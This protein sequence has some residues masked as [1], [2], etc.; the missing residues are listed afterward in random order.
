MGYDRNFIPPK[1]VGDGPFVTFC[2]WVWSRLTVP[3]IDTDTIKWSVTTRGV[4][5]RAITRKTAGGVATSGMVFRG[6][7]NPAESYNSQE[8]VFYTPSG[9]SAGAY[10]G[11]LDDIP[12]GTIP[13]TGEP[14]W[15][16]WPYPPPGVWG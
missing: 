7:Y 14:Y 8:V 3:F 15:C 6:G 11:L 5:A 1:P 16:A 4:S 13:D 9:G 2:Q 10:I 12:T